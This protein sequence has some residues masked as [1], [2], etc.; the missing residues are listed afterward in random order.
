MVVKLMFRPVGVLAGLLARR[1]FALLWRAVDEQAPPRP[2][3]RRAGVAKL[4][5]A[6]SLE[7]AVFRLVKGVVDNASRRGFAAVTG[8]W[9]GEDGRR[10]E[11]DGAT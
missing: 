10:R 11:R 6:L 5:L 1:T 7:G 4:A 2:E 3:Q 9:P 8:L